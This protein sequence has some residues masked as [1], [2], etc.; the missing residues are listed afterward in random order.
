LT[1]LGSLGAWSGRKGEDVQIGERQSRD[2]LQSDVEILAGL[3]R[4]AN[5]YIGANRGVR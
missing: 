4:K 3:A 1:E 5:D 2:E